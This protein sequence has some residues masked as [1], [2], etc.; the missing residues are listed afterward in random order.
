MKPS[1]ENNDFGRGAFLRKM[2]LHSGTFNL[3]DWEQRFLHSFSS[4]GRSSLWFTPKRR[5][6]VDQLWIK[7]GNEPEIGMPFLAGAPVQ[8]IEADP[9]GCQFKLYEDG[10]Q[11]PCNEP[12]V[13]MRQSG[14]RYCQSHTDEVLRTLKRR[15]QTMHLLPFKS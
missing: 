9:S 7:F 15:G 10:K 8:A 13:M 14:F 3:S 5:L 12:A 1:P 11:R 2:L 6:A 4:V